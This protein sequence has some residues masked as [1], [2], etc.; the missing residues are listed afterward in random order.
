MFRPPSQKILDPPL[1]VYT[2]GSLWGPWV[3]GLI[4]EVSGN[5]GQGS[6]KYHMSAKD[7]MPSS[8]HFQEDPDSKSSGEISADM[9]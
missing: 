7:C 3:R 2:V 6:Q 4:I 1:C 5:T 8:V 9:Q